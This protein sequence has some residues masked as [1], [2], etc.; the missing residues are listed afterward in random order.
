[1]CGAG[2]PITTIVLLPAAAR[3]AS[4]SR[5]SQRKACSRPFGIMVI[6]RRDAKPKCVWRNNPSENGAAIRTASGDRHHDRAEPG[7]MQAPL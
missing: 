7:P 5:A 1:L 4:E 3:V 2:E 6:L